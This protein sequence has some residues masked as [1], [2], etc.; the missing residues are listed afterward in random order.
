[1]PTINRTVKVKQP[2]QVYQHTRQS[3]QY[4]NTLQ[5]KN[6]RNSYIKEHPFCQ[7]CYDHYGRIR[8]AEEVHHVREILSGLTEEER[9]ELL[10]DRDNL[11]SVCRDCHLEI[12]NQKRKEITPGDGQK[13]QG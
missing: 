10:L 3:Q 9:M 4:Y 5:W 1:M 2:K 8:L 6:L 7:Y 13:E 11:M 12:H